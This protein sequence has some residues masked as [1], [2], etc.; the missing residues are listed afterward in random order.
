MK[1]LLSLFLLLLLAC[2]PLQLPAQAADLTGHWSQS[3]VESLMDRGIL[4]G[5]PDGAFRP[6]DWVKRGEAARMVRLAA[7]TLPYTLPVTDQ[8]DFDDLT[9]HWAR[10]DVRQLVLEGVIVPAEYGPSFG[11]NQKA[12]RLEMV[13]MVLRLLGFSPDRDTAQPSGFPDLDSLGAQ[14][15]YYCEKA[16]E[17]GL[18]Q[19]YSD[20]LFRPLFPLTRGEA[21]A[22]L[23]RALPQ[24]WVDLTGLL[25]YGE[26]NTLPRADPFFPIL[27]Q[28]ATAGSGIYQGQPV[29]VYQYALDPDS[30]AQLTDCL[31]RYTQALNAQR[32]S[33]VAYTEEET[34][35]AYRFHDL[36]GRRSLLLSVTTQDE[37]PSLTV[38][39]WEDAG[40]TG[41]YAA[42]IDRLGAPTL[43]K[44]WNVAPLAFFST[45]EA[46][47]QAFTEVYPLELLPAGMAQHFTAGLLAAG[48]RPQ[49]EESGTR[50]EKEGCSLWV[51]TQ[52]GQL[53]IRSLFA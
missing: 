5:D 17:L 14:D 45:G 53:L 37:Q 7:S 48:Y 15:R 3:A 9:G 34:E 25:A 22:I 38:A 46:S 40:L 30:T 51:T 11:P 24:E 1:R 19:G 26:D 44:Q 20:S 41:Q 29:T 8:A 27:R 32:Y 23:Q 12:T 10:N 50:Y 28:T 2:S 33:L 47:G 18:I 6:D 43:C 13:K 39:L 52:D 21:A 4:S 16:V 49:T 42:Y 31:R 36:Q 35:Q